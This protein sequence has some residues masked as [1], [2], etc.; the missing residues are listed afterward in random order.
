[1]RSSISQFYGKA[2]QILCKAIC[3]QSKWPQVRIYAMS[4]RRVLDRE[5]RGEAI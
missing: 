1:M 2:N 5:S 4:V 3:L